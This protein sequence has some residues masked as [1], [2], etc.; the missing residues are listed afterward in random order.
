LALPAVGAPPS[1][2]WRNLPSCRGAY[3]HWWDRLHHTRPARRLATRLIKK[4]L[5]FG[6]VADRWPDYRK[7]HKYYW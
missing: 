3:P 6:E 7:P 1:E 4:A 2:A 5:A